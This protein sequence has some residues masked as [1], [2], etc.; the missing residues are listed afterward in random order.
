MVNYLAVSTADHGNSVTYH[1]TITGSSS[2]AGKQ[3]T[4]YVSTQTGEFGAQRIKCLTG[5]ILAIGYAG[6]ITIVQGH[7]FVSNTRSRVQADRRDD[8]LVNMLTLS[9]PARTVRYSSTRCGMHR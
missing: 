2:T 5:P 7:H 8:V 4:F 9:S 6:E 3:Y 1:A